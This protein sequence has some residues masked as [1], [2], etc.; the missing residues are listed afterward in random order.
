MNKMKKVAVVSMK[1]Q[2]FYVFGNAHRVG[3]SVRPVLKVEKIL[4]RKLVN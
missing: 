3:L 4:K 2:I 1:M